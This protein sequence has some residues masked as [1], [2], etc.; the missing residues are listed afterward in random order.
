MKKQIDYSIYLVTDQSLMSTDTLTEAVEQAILGGCTLVQLREKDLSSLDFYEIAMEIRQLTQRYGIPLIINDRIDIALAVGAD[1]VHI[2]QSDIPAAVARRII[3]NDMVLG[4]SASSVEEALQAAADGADC[5]GIGAMFPTG[6]KEDAKIVTMEELH[7]IRKA[8]SI[9]IVVIGGINKENAV[10]FKAAGV[11]GLAVVS[12]IISQP[13][14]TAATKELNRIFCGNSF[15]GAIFDLD[16]TALDSMDVWERIDIAFLE[17]RGFAVPEDYVVKICSMSFAE[18]AVYTADLF[19]LPEKPEDI[20]AEWNDM[21]IDEYSHRIGLKPYV[22]D[23][24]KKLK[25]RGIK[26]GVATGLPKVLYEPVLKNNGIYDLF[27]SFT[28]TDEVARGK[29][30]PEVFLLAAKKLG[31]EPHECV[32]FEDVPEGIKTAKQAGMT[33]YGVHDKYSEKF[34]EDIKHIA[35]GY[36]MDFSEAPDGCK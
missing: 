27:D 2:G 34:K 18:A 29:T 35:D 36:I 7:R 17:K 8:V 14:I 20:I 28:S 9:P 10:D 1:G 3:R 13:D 26:L 15:K 22:S 24:L 31:L 12:A 6:T 23:Y 11:D 5:L 4:V 19:S 21:A 32:A 33:V 16:G 25:T 30:F